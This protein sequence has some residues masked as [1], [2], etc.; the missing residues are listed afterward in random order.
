[1]K[2]LNRQAYEDV[3]RF[4]RGS[5]DE[6]ISQYVVYNH[7]IIDLDT[8]PVTISNIT[9]EPK[10]RFDWH[11]HHAQGG[12]GQILL[13]TA[14]EGWYQQEGKKPVHL[15]EGS[16]IYIPAGVKHW[17]GALQ[18][19]WFSHLCI[20]IKG[21]NHETQWMESVD[22][23]YYLGLKEGPVKKTFMP[24]GKQTKISDKASFNQ[25]NMFGTGIYNFLMKK[26]FN[27]PSY[28]KMISLPGKTPL[29]MANVNFTPACANNWHTHHATK[30]GGQILICT[31]G[32][33]W[34]QEEGHA[35]E[36]LEPGTIKYIPA[37]VKHWHGSQK[38]TW[39]SHIAVELPGEDSKL[40]W[41]EPVD[42]SVLSRL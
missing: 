39:F 24:L 34:Y 23:H 1:M 13:C 30:A 40:S 32:Q 8:C 36:R 33:G 16:Y 35:A 25:A 7:S 5:K 28:L 4:A 10:S 11:S 42:K 14:G 19:S 2:Y 15:S 6:S 9:F 41:Y 21:E 20:D 29:F 17:H 18:D 38:D 3:N 27:G 12:G 31:V 22:D 37:G 26:Y